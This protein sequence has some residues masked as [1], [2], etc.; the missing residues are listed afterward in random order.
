MLAVK[1]EDEVK[2][3]VKDLDRSTGPPLLHCCFPE[4]YNIRLLSVSW[5]DPIVQCC[6]YR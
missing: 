1:D 6:N 3:I 2:H 5:C 4:R